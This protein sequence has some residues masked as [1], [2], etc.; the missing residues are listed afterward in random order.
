METN[1]I[2][3]DMTNLTTISDS[4]P[5]KKKRKSSETKN[6]EKKQQ[7]PKKPKK[8]KCMSTNN[9]L[10]EQ[11]VS[12]SVSNRQFD[13]VSSL[14]TLS[15]SSS[16][17]SLSSSLSYS[18]SFKKYASKSILHRMYCIPL[19]IISSEDLEHIKQGC[20]Q[21]I[22]GDTPK[23]PPIQIE[24][25]FIRDNKWL[26]V[27]RVY[28][29][30]KMGLPPTNQLSLGEP[31][32]SDVSW[33]AEL[34]E[35]K[36]R[37]QKSA[38]EKVRSYLEKYHN[39]IL[40]AQTGMGKTRVGLS[41]AHALKRK[42]LW[43]AHKEMLL[44][45]AK[46]S[47]QDYMPGVR[48]GWIQ[49]DVYDIQN[50]DIVFA[51]IQTLIKRK[52][53]MSFEDLD[54]FGTV[55]FDECHH[56]GARTFSKLLQY[57]RPMYI[58][59]LS[60]TPQRS[61]NV[62]LIYQQI[63]HV[64]FES[65]IPHQTH[66]KVTVIDYKNNYSQS[67]LK[68][69]IEKINNKIFRRTVILKWLAKDF[70]RN[71]LILDYVCKSLMEGR[72]TMVLVYGVEHLEH[73]VEELH[74]RVQYWDAKPSIGRLHGNRSLLKKKDLP[75]QSECD[76]IFATLDYA[77]EGLDLPDLNTLIFANLDSDPV[78]PVGR[79]LRKN[80]EDMEMSPW[81]VLLK[82]E[83][84][85]D[86]LYWKFM[87]YFSQH[88]FI[89]QNTQHIVEDPPSSPSAS[90][91]SSSSSSSVSLFGDPDLS[92]EQEQEHADEEEEKQESSTNHHTSHVSRVSY[93]NRDNTIRLF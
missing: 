16:S 20:T 13:F 29:I 87:K 79:L 3:S 33:T 49:Q 77:R 81:V 90:N 86:G 40:K 41:I 78:Q 80:K 21:T 2:S 67:K 47:S 55:I 84:I 7:H 68:D 60:A 36:E 1:N 66:V 73:L 38:H 57:I 46:Q 69:K 11:E 26:L 32:S 76:V 71:N 14:P 27:P 54:S 93:V 37:P 8:Q 19:H 88:K 59:G 31:M 58:L 91:T 61:K 24:S 34:S 12:V 4:N 74:K 72:K 64:V 10:T 18:S 51:T 35:T 22:D 52:E 82:E 39:G 45:Q 48:M 6:D 44:L 65:Q 17:S 30:S 75:Q 83:G 43:I 5:K 23:D 56:Y 63:G 28:G 62:D 42:V 9:N 85:F 70:K 92:E 25:F 15:F 53:T 89:I 50:K